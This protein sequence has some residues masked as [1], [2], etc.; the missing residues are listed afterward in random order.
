VGECCS[1]REQRDQEKQE[2][3]PDPHHG[4]QNESAS[5]FI[6]KSLGASLAS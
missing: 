3:L 6:V 4:L 5:I 1:G 2:N